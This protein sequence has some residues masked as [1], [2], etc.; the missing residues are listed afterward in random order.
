MVEAM[1]SKK[2]K[3]ILCA[4]G[5]SD[6]NLISPEILQHL[7]E[8]GA[9]VKVTESESPKQF[10]L[11]AKNNQKGEEV[12]VTCNKQVEMNIELFIRHGCFLELRNIKW[13]V[14]MSEMAEPILGRPILEALGINT[15]DLLAAAVDQVGSSLDVSHLDGYQGS[16]GGSIARILN[17]GIYHRDKGMTSDEYDDEDEAWFDLG[18]DTEQEVDNG[19]LNAAKEA[20][21]N[22]ISNTGKKTLS[23]MLNNYRDVLRLRLGNDPPALVDAMKVE[24]KEDLTPIAAKT[25]RYTRDGRKFMEHYVDRVIEYGF[26]KVTTEAKWVAARV[27]VAKPAPPLFRLTFDYRP[28]KAATVP[29]TR[30]MPDIDSEMADLAGSKFFA[31]I[32]FVSGYWQLPLDKKSQLL[33]SFMTT[34]KVVCPTRCTQGAK[35]AGANFQSIV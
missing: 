30:P 2:F 12:F 19:I 33:L 3:T 25:R 1:F 7:F 35:N 23:S 27:L 6:I 10:G 31:V 18:K 13:Y 8:K 17:E 14:A 22:G 32:D 21:D 28:I 11:A 16:P 4:D 9:R 15:R 5:G 24:L 29:M 20:E 26:G 34:N